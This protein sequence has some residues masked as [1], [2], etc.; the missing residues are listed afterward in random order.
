MPEKPQQDGRLW[1]N[2]YVVVQRQLRGAG[3][4]L[5]RYPPPRAKENPNKMAG[6]AKSHLES[7]P[8]PARD[9]QRANKTC[10]H[11]DPETEPELC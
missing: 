8:R 7:N 2:G 9:A 6:G 10:V 1:S 11:Q 4:T 3:A 5:R